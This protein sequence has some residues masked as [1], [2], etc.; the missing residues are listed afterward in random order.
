M[1]WDLWNLKLSAKLSSLF[2]AITAP[3]YVKK[4][5]RKVN[6]FVDA[7]E[8]LS[9]EVVICCTWSLEGLK[10]CERA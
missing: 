1:E 2:N 5:S 10:V 7:L 9:I 3:R 4:E 8:F 6:F